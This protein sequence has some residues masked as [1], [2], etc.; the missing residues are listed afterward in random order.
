ME[1]I[2]RDNAT[3]RALALPTPSLAQLHALALPR[4]DS[5][6]TQRTLQALGVIEPSKPRLAGSALLAGLEPGGGRSKPGG[7]KQIGGGGTAAAG[8]AAKPKLDSGH[9]FFVVDF[10]F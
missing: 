1:L 2:E 3:R 9:R 8:A 5:D 10:K 7:R 4:L 6:Q